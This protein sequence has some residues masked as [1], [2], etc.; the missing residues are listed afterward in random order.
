MLVV[1]GMQPTIRSDIKSWSPELHAVL[2]Y[3][4]SKTENFQYKATAFKVLDILFDNTD[5]NGYF[6]KVN[7]AGK[8]LSQI[9]GCAAGARYLRSNST[10]CLLMAREE[11]LEWW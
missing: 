9:T 3:F 5:H 1:F 2:M 8:Q 10:L 6:N 7:I 4:T 11:S